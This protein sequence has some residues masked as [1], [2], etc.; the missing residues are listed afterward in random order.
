MK[1]VGAISISYNVECP[2]CEE[3]MYSD[4]QG[5]WWDNNFGVDFGIEDY[6]FSCEYQVR[7]NDCGK[8]FSVEEFRV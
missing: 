2:H 7:C 1:Q 5:D 6:D 8:Q 4:I 3:T